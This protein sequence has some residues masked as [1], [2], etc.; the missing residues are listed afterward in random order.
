MLSHAPCQVSVSL[1]FDVRQK[2]R[3][4]DLKAAAL[5][6]IY[7]FPSGALAEAS[8]RHAHLVTASMSEWPVYLS[9][10][11]LDAAGDEV[12]ITCWFREEDRKEPNDYPRL[13]DAEITGTLHD[14]VRGV[15][16]SMHQC[17]LRTWQN[18]KDRNGNLA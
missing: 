17:T 3:I 1:I 12:S 13:F 6:S 16:F 5:G 11:V 7:Q 14:Y 10:K 8:V 18:L 4:A 9:G 15:G 2:M